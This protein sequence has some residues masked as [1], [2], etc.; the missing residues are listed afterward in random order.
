[1]KGRKPKPSHLHLV[2]GNP[3]KRPRKRR[4]PTPDLGIPNPPE[5][6]SPAARIAWGAM[7]VKLNEMGVL[8]YADAWA[9]EQLAENY[10]EILAWRE[11]I[12]EKGRMVTVTMSNDELR[13]VVNP[14]CIALSDTEKRFRAMMCEF[15]LTPSSRTRVDAKT[16]SQEK[17]D[18]AA[19]YFK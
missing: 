7:A 13:D 10:A 5:H 3:G 16:E 19:R 2:N 15:G 18:P 6:L 4:E 11:L 1:M 9:L 17:V 12:E 14:A 8:A